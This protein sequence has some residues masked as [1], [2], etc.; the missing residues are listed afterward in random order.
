[1]IHILVVEDDKNLR[2][3]MAVVLKQNDYDVTTSTC[4]EEALE[5]LGHT[6][7]DLVVSDIMM[8]GMDGFAL[9]ESIRV[10]NPYLPIL[11]VTAKEHIDDKK[12]GFK[13][14]TDDYMVKPID[15]DEL[16]L[17][18][19][20]LLRR[21]RIV[22]DHRLTF[23]NTTI[24]AQ[25]LTL[26]YKDQQHIL[27]KKEFLLLFKFLSYPKKIFTRQ[28]LMDEIWGLTT[29]SDER[30]VDV[31]IRRLRNR[32]AN[33]SDFEIITVRGLGYKGEISYEAD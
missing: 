21:S 14:G 15:M 23:K 11:I 2:R 20:A 18:I 3:L 9:T 28:Q 5:I 8:P 25:S 24:D 6:H 26:T 22:I 27:P 16:I 17:R 29:E 32:V 13:L 12:R 31:H 10:T 30:T 4:G 19:S 33:I 7:V 1:M